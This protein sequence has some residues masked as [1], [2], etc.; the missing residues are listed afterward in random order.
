MVV[1]VLGGVVLVAILLAFM[2]G[3]RRPVGRAK[4]YGDVTPN[5]PE[6]ETLTPSASSAATQDQA[7]ASR[8]QTPPA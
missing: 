7:D 3:R 6:A 8:R 1:L 5:V 4:P 2:S